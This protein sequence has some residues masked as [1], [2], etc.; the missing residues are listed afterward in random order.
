MKEQQEDDGQWRNFKKVVMWQ[1]VAVNCG[2]TIVRNMCIFGFCA[3]LF[4][5]A[6]KRYK[7]V[8]FPLQQ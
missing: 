6:L 3:L 5:C 8:L 1:E 4:R 2:K 7:T